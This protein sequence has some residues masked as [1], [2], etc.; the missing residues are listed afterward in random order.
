L[1]NA[2]LAPTMMN[3][4]EKQSSSTIQET[5]L[6]KVRS[7]ININMKKRGREIH[8]KVCTEEQSQSKIEADLLSKV[9]MTQTKMKNVHR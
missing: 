4:E 8:N 1:T 6:L 2:D 5:T 9:M 3:N 7:R